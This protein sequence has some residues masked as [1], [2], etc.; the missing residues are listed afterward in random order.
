M[1]TKITSILTS[2]ILTATSFGFAVPMS[3]ADQVSKA[4]AIM[5]LV[6]VEVVDLE[7]NDDNPMFK[8][9]AKCRIVSNYTDSKPKYDFIY[10][11]CNYGFDEDPSPLMQGDDCIV[12]LELMEV[13]PVGHPISWN[14]THLIQRRKV[15][16]PESKNDEAKILVEVFEKRIRKLLANKK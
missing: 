16:D 8:Q 11:P 4:N 2:I 14:A 10:V 7:Y 13:S 6:V 15:I 3:L 12:F 9:L 5:R 1:K